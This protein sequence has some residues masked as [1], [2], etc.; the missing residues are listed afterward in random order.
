[1]A[2]GNPAAKRV[3]RELGAAGPAKNPQRSIFSFLGH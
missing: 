2:A 1:M 3:C